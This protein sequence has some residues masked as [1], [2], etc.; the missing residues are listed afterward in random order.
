MTNKPMLSVG[1]KLSNWSAEERYSVPKS[2][3]VDGQRQSL[4][5]PNKIPFKPDGFK[6]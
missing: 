6:P 4:P 1:K 2:F 3:M 5:K